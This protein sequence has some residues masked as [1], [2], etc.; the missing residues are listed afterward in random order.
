MK[1]GFCLREAKNSIV[2]VFQASPQT[3]LRPSTKSGERGFEESL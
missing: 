1:G 3:P 2:G